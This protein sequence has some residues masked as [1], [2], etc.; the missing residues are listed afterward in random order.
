VAR[1]FI[2][3]FTCSDSLSAPQS[4]YM[5]IRRLVISAS[6]STTGQEQNPVNRE[7][8]R[9]GCILSIKMENLSKTACRPCCRLSSCS[10]QDIQCLASVPNAA[11]KSNSIWLSQTTADL[12][13]PSDVKSGNS[14]SVVDSSLPVHINCNP[15]PDTLAS[16]DF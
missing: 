16:S 1:V 8:F 4:P 3:M 10:S 5:R 14:Q 7:A 13:R 11:V 15:V 12:L 9:T 6:E 2:I